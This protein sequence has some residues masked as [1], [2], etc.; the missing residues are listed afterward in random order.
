MPGASI[1]RSSLSSRSIVGVYRKDLETVALF[2]N[3]TLSNGYPKRRCLLSSP[4]LTSSHSIGPVGRLY[5][6]S[7]TFGRE[8][9]ASRR[10]TGNVCCGGGGGILRR[11]QEVRFGG[12][13]GER[14]TRTTSRTHAYC[15]GVEYSGVGVS[16][17][18]GYVFL[19]ASNP[20]WGEANPR[21]HT[22]GPTPS[23]R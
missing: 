9:L 15:S 3:R 17:G 2:L 4:L 21:M 13:Q 23:M 19:G 16:R 5:S 6:S 14:S 20:F 1:H 18:V 11:T 8:T 12:R 7:S 10:D 22:R